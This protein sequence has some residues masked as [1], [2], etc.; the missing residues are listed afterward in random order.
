MLFRSHR[1]LQHVI[2]RKA[3]HEDNGGYIEQRTLHV[4]AIR[5]ALRSFKHYE[6]HHFVHFVRMWATASAQFVEI[7]RDS[8]SLLFPHVLNGPLNLEFVRS[9]IE[10]LQSKF[11][12]SSLSVIQLRLLLLELLSAI[13]RKEEADVVR[14]QLT[15]D[16]NPHREVL[17]L[18]LE[19]LSLERGAL[20]AANQEYLH[21]CV[22][23]LK[24]MTELKYDGWLE[25]KEIGRASCR[26]RV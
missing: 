5:L 9:A 7:A 6:Y 24:R 10:G 25:S 13:G 18:H 15:A 14:N 11:G 12:D 23:A 3:S 8:Q 22:D 19:I 2:R 26:E 20:A 21:Q 17:H 4:E 16:D 1:L